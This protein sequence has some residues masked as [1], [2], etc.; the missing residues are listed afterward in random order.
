MAVDSLG[1]CSTLPG[2][3]A[4]TEC[5]QSGATYF[6]NAAVA[7][8]GDDAGMRFEGRVPRVNQPLKQESI[9][10]AHSSKHPTYNHRMDVIAK[11][12]GGGAI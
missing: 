1:A 9:R 10:P 11:R 12:Q 3:D 5:R 6:G 8:I 7:V 4:Q 2:A